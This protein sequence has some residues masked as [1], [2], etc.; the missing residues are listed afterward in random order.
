MFLA[1]LVEKLRVVRGEDVIATMEWLSHEAEQ[2]LLF[3]CVWLSPL[4]YNAKSIEASIKIHN[5]PITVLAKN[6]MAEF[7]W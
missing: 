6:Y 1:T 2:E 7:T 3:Y 4:I 5:Q